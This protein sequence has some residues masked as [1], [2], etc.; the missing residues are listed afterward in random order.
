M[1]KGSVFDES[2][3]KTVEEHQPSILVE[4]FESLYAN[5]QMILDDLS[6]RPLTRQSMPIKCET[7]ASRIKMYELHK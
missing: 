1:L 3:E 4:N 2:L 7:P 6:S 5:A